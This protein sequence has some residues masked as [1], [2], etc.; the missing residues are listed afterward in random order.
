M[1]HYLVSD[2][3]MRLWD[4]MSTTKMTAKKSDAYHHGD[5]RAALLRAAERILERDGPK[6]ISL[7]ACAKEAGVSHAGPTHH[8]PSLAALLSALAAIG[9]DR[10]TRSV[11]E[12]LSE[13]DA[14]LSTVSRTYVAFALENRQ[15]FY[16]MSDPGRLDSTYP[17]L[18]AARSEARDALI[19]ARAVPAEN[20]SL[21]QV[22][23]IAAEWALAHGFALLML[24]ERLGGLTRMVSGGAT[25]MD[26]LDAA[27]RALNRT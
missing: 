18:R 26:L 11:C 14:A 13:P 27:L 24:T 8:F 2:K 23:L 17:D 21:D 12:A 20:A 9:F 19:S 7:R 22:G 5:L 10:L 15:M 4:N 1:A 3:I 16:L 25:E 6:A